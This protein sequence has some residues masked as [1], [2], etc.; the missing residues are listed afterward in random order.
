M[1]HYTHLSMRERCNLTTFLEMGLSMSEIAKRMKRHRSTL[2]R[3]LSRNHTHH[4][5][6]PGLAD[7]Q[8]NKRRPRKSLKLQTDAQ[9]YH[10]VYDRLKAGWS[11]EQIVGRMRLEK[12]SFAI[13]S[14]TIYQYVYQHGQKKLWQ[15]LPSKQTKRRKR[16]ARRKA[17][18]RYG[19]IRLITKRPENI[20]KRD[21]IGH[22]EGDLIAFSGTKKK[23]VTTLLERKTR[24]VILL[25]NSTKVSQKVMSKIR[26]TFVEQADIPCKT[27]TFDQ[28]GE[29][30]AY[31][32]IEKAMSCKVYYCQTHSPWQK[33]SNENMNGR[34][35]RYLPRGT[36]INQIS[37]RELD[38][39]AEKMNTL[40]RKCLGF[41]TPKELFLKHIH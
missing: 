5:Y 32:I 23:A 38:H 10:Y 9:L 15:Y 11:P 33:G 13:C 29:F 39:L 2:Y 30:A 8:A 28:G 35:R 40:P 6:R 22:W 16:C 20:E 41:R 26:N 1:G 27:I 25:K 3:E 4:R 17:D 21:R 37:Q 7:Q 12:K 36:Q 18:C 34:L 24:M 19:D 31:P 14:E